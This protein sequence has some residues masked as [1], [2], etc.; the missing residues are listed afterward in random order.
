L[1]H[2]L[3]GVEVLVMAENL[4]HKRQTLRRHPHSAALQ[5]FDEAIAR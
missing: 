5:E 4:I 1:L 3:V 2:E